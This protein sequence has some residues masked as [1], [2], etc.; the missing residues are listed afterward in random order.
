MDRGKTISWN[1]LIVA[2]LAVVAFFW[3]WLYQYVGGAG[4]WAVFIAFAV[5]LAYG[6]AAKKL[7]WMVIGAVVGALLGFLT[8]AL[9]NL[10]FPPYAIISSAIAG[11]I[12]LLVAGLLSLPRFLDIMPMMVVG[13]AVFLGALA[14]FEFLFIEQTVW[15]FPKAYGTLVGVILSLLVGLLIGAVVATPIV[16]AATQKAA[17]K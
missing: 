8:F 2:I 17:G 6:A 12:F 5:Y 1:L 7:P 11:A 16:S 9:A 14:R 10:I 13:W 3:I 4:Y 15:A